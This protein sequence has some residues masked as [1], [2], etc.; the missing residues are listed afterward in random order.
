[1]KAKN[2]NCLKFMAKVK[3]DTL[4]RKESCIKNESQKNIKRRLTNIN[5]IIVKIFS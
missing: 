5:K 2:S 1:M 4:L 3:S